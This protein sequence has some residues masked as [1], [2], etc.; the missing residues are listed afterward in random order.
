MLQK[1]KEIYEFGPFRLDV[2]EHTFAR[3]DGTRNGSLPEKAFLTLSFLVRNHGR[4]LTKQELLDHVWP[5]SFVEENN[6]DKS[7]HAIRHAIGE[8]PREQK[9]IATV[10]KH[11]Y[12][13]VADVKRLCPSRTDLLYTDFENRTVDKAGDVETFALPSVKA[14]HEKRR[15]SLRWM[16]PVI[17]SLVGVII[18]LFVVLGNFQ[19]L[20]SGPL[21]TTS[22]NS[23]A[24]MPFV[25]ETGSA[26]FDYVSDGMTES[27]I[28]RLSQVTDLNV[29][30][31]SIVFRYKNKD[32]DPVTI[33][34]ALSV[35]GVLSGR[36]IQRDD[37]L[38]LSL[39]LTDARTGNQL[40]GGQ[41]K[42]GQ[43]N[44]VTLPG[45]IA[46]D[47]IDKLEPNLSDADKSRLTKYYTEN[48][49]AYLLYL[50][51][52]FHWN[53]R[54]TVQDFE[55]AIEYFEQAIAIDPN[56]SL[57]YAGLSDANLGLSAFDARPP[58]E[59]MPKVR[60]YAQKA[61]M[62]DNQ[63]AE[64]HAAMGNVLFYSDHDFEGAEREFQL[65]I[66]L[67]PK[68][69]ATH[70]FY[71]NLLRSLG[72]HDEALA[73]SGHALGID[74]LSLLV[75]WHHGN[76]LMFARRY[77][78]AIEQ[79]KKTVELDTTFVLAHHSLGVAYELQGNYP[80]SVEAFAK[81]EELTGNLTNA[82]W[83]R[84]S[85][86]NDGWKGYLKARQKRLRKTNMSMRY[87]A[88][89]DATFGEKD[90]AIA[91]LNKSYDNREYHLVL[92]KVD[93]RLDSLREDPRFVQLVQRVGF[94]E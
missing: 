30:A 10:R 80:A 24:V 32:Y 41:Y 69:A 46:R 44:L 21:K 29:K 51:G 18:L 58:M 65:A 72:R 19:P 7:I 53:K 71:S 63:L 31:R 9:Y 37:L 74:P 81:Y 57:A 15:N 48:T 90:L 87:P 70:H 14:T 67:N 83:T 84:E 78:E 62:L 64:A 33:G 76:N 11:G 66:E 59:W 60:V 93:P 75:N 55:K 88:A 54:R 17:G 42:R 4:L 56:Y 39:E 86:L 89:L 45:E 38:I 85:F 27:L 16:L 34:N 92:L 5:D 2:T 1:E 82:K 52:R 43:F 49:D 12:R 68:Y 13:F 26:D 50:K 20:G 22:I 91:E 73:K 3:I 25:N 61:L 35:R 36:I 8:K 47:V 79:L 28:N 94:P 40:W 6:L 77:D 23:I